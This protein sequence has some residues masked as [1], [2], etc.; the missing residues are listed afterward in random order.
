MSD[1]KITSVEKPK[2]PRRVEAGKRL[3]AISRQAK[4]KKIDEKNVE[5]EFESPTINP[6][7]AIGIV[8]VVGMVA[9]YGYKSSKKSPQDKEVVREEFP[10]AKEVVREAEQVKRKS[11][12]V[13]ADRELPVMG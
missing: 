9:Y 10:Q 7:T 4:E 3:G 8:C 5:A 1:T 12:V 6:L 2:D 13:Q 11:P